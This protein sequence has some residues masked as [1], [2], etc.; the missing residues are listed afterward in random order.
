M[1]ARLSNPIIPYPTGRF[2]FSYRYLA[3]PRRGMPGYFHDVPT[4]QKHLT[5]V[6]EFGATSLRAAGFD[7]KDSD[8]TEF[9]EVLLDEACGL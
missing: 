3:I 9:A 1:V 8:S 7:D 5:P 2:P 6:H 4:G